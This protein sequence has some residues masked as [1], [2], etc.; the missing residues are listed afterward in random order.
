MKKLISLT[1]FTTS[2]LLF[3]CGNEQKEVDETLKQE[4]I[5]LDSTNQVLESTAEEI[6]ETNAEVKELM[7]EI[8]NL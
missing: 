8:D 3:S 1:L 2:L 5:Q 7:D 6:Q 4:I